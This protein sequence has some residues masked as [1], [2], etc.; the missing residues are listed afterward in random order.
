MTVRGGEGCRDFLV[1][2]AAEEGAIDG[3]ACNSNSGPGA[4]GHGDAEEVGM[5]PF[6]SRGSSLVCF[7]SWLTTFLG[8]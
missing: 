5:K 1:A 8:A 6:L 7:S 3:V 2:A 4:V